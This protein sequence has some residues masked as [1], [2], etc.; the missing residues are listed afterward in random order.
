MLASSRRFRSLKEL[1]QAQLS[2][3]TSVEVPG[4]MV[5]LPHLKRLDVYTALGTVAELTPEF[6][7]SLTWILAEQSGDG[8]LCRDVDDEVRDKFLQHISPTFAA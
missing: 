5:M 1:I 2:D 3:L 6:L 4:I 7:K 8:W